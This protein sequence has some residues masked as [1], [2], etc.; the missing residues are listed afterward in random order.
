MNREDLDNNQGPMN[1]EDRTA[2]ERTEVSNVQADAVSEPMHVYN[3]HRYYETIKESQVKKKG[4]KMKYVAG[5]LVASIVGGT[6]AGAGF[7]FV[8]PYA[9]AQYAARTES[10]TEPLAERQEASSIKTDYAQP[11]VGGGATPQGLYNPVPAI[12]ENVGPSVVSI[13][14]TKTV[15]AWGTQYSESGL[16]SGVI[17]AVNDSKVYIVSNAH[18]VEGASTLVVNFLGNYKVPGQIVG[19]DTDSDI[20]VV[21]VLLEDIPQEIRGAIKPAAFGDDDSLRVGDLAIAIGTPIDEAYNN[22]V[23]VGYI[24]ALDREINLT[25]KSFSLIQT[26]AAINPGNSG[27]ALVGPTGEVIGINTIKL[28]DRE[29]EGMGF[30]IPINDVKPIVEELM[31]NGRIIRPSLGIVGTDLTQSPNPLFPMPMGIGVIEVMPG[32]SANMAGIQAG[33]IINIPT[34]GEPIKTIESLQALLKEKKVGDTIQ[35]EIVR[36]T[37]KFTLDVKLQESPQAGN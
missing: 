28:V 25:D 11:V 23:T 19:Y 7:A 20:A 16:G 12:A 15:N 6:C 10:Q 8:A 29:I 18:V 22:T 33:D 34:D 21:E 4:S 3:N 17:Y 5:V 2:T 13:V 30:A 9:N 24:S 31:L 37:E 32:S 26:D 1:E 35:V 36:N 27:G 14:N